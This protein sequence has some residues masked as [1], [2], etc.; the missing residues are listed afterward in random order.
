M[1]GGGGEAG[2]L[3]GLQLSGEL[4]L[5]HST[6]PRPPPCI[7]TTLPQLTPLASFTPACSDQ[8]PGYIELHPAFQAK[9]VSQ[10]YICSVNDLFVVNA[11][12]DHLLGMAALQPSETVQFAADYRGEWAAAMG[13][14]M[15]ARK[16]LGSF[17]AQR[18]AA[19]IEDG[20]VVK[21]IVEPV[22]STRECRGVVKVVKGS[23]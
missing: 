17:R 3:L 20:K 18:T 15:D 5:V 22:S 23:F 13:I 6:A 1:S 7:P 19:I 8:V 9:G 11:W 12:R 10:I 2:R 4:A 21:L 14:V 16:G